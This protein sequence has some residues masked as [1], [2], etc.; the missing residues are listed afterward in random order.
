MSEAR[1]LG[2]FDAEPRAKDTSSER[3]TRWPQK[4]AGIKV[5]RSEVPSKT[6][7][8]TQTPSDQYL[9]DPL[10]RAS[11]QRWFRARASEWTR[12]TGAHSSM[13]IRR[14]HDAYK[15]IVSVGWP[16]VPLLLE[17]LREMPDMWFPALREITNENPVHPDDRGNYDKMSEAWRAWGR[18]KHLIA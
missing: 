3:H 14:R 12:E 5:T 15:A 6:I 2:F 13:T 8:V 11:K 9:L 18:D 17:A 16:M 4:G 1:L 10:Y 7:K